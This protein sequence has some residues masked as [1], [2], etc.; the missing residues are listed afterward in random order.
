MK[1]FLPGVS[2]RNATDVSN[3]GT[4]HF[5]NT[6]LRLFQQT[7]ND[8]PSTSDVLGRRMGTEKSGF[9]EKAQTSAY[10][11]QCSDLQHTH[12]KGPIQM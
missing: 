1:P 10:R 12:N 5:A 8:G 9:Q 2:V 3:S 4:H 7:R 11:T 6:K